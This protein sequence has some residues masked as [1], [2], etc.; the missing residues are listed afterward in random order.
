MRVLDQFKYPGFTMRHCQLL[1]G[2]GRSFQESHLSGAKSLGRSSA[3]KLLILQRKGTKN[4]SVETDGIKFNGRVKL[5][6]A[7]IN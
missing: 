7:N 3:K 2:N 6:P 5:S 4:S 1:F